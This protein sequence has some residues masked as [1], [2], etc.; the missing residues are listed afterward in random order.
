MNLLNLEGLKETM[1]RFR[2]ERKLTKEVSRE[3]GRRKEMVKLGMCLNMMN[4]TPVA[5]ARILWHVPYAAYQLLQCTL[6]GTNNIVLA[7][8]NL[9][10]PPLLQNP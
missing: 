1:R 2:L 4:S 3:I 7:S 10:Q 5:A 9:S 8:K 6:R